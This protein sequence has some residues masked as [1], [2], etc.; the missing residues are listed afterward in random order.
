MVYFD[1]LVTIQRQSINVQYSRYVKSRKYGPHRGIY[2]NISKTAIAPLYFQ[3]YN[4]ISYSGHP[5]GSKQYRFAK[6]WGGGGG[7]T[8][9]ISGSR[10]KCHFLSKYIYNWCSEYL[11]FSTRVL[12][13]YCIVNICIYHILYVLFDYCIPGTNVHTGIL[14]MD[15]TTAVRRNITFICYVGRYGWD[16]ASEENWDWFFDFDDFMRSKVMKS[17]ISSII[18]VCA[19][20]VHKYEFF[21]NLRWLKDGMEEKW[22]W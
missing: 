11:L 12:N 19:R 14:C 20:R 7:Y 3:C 4:P 6:M 8:R 15:H 1:I 16:L 13:K 21:W 5:R 9:V 22:V 2:T 18:H 17:A 10:P